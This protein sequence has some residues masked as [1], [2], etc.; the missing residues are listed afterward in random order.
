MTAFQQEQQL[1][2]GAVYTATITEIRWT[3]KKLVCCLNESTYYICVH[4]WTTSDLHQNV[5]SSSSGI[6]VSWWSSIPIWVPSCCI[7]RSWI[8]NGFV[9]KKDFERS[10]ALSSYYQLWRYFPLSDQTSER[11]GFRSGA[12]DSGM[13]Q[14]L[15]LC[16][17]PCSC[18]HVSRFMSPT[19]TTGQVLWT[20]PNRWPD[21][22]FQEGA[23]VSCRYCRQDS[24]WEAEHL[25][26]TDQ[27]PHDR[28]RLV[29]QQKRQ[30]AP[31]QTDMIKW[32]ARPPGVV[33]LLELNQMNM[34]LPVDPTEMMNIFSFFGFPLCISRRPISCPSV[35]EQAMNGFIFKCA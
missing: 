21:E 30:H 27:Q 32:R 34:G 8:T 29:T 17:Q 24:E 13:C 7:T 18:D 2:F 14:W 22:T 12:A 26:G 6:S 1:E 23:A 31:V 28:R 5:S 3:W 9:M 35:T 11:S 10:K 33:P 25:H 20:G 15:Q 16:C 19:L 4:V